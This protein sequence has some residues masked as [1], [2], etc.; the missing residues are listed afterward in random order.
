[1]DKELKLKRLSRILLFAATV[2]WGSTFFIMKNT[3]DT[4]G[5]SFIMAARFTIGTVLLTLIFLPRLKKFNVG[6]FIGGAITG[7][8]LALAS[9]VQTV[10][11]SYTTPGKNA[12]LT[13]VY[14]VIV[15]FLYWLTA[16]K[17]PTVYNVI[18][19]FICIV[20]IGFVTLNKDLKF[21]AGDMLTLLSGIFYAV[22][23]LCIKKFGENRDVFLF[24]IAQF[25]FTA[26]ICWI[27]FAIFEEFP[28][29]VDVGGWLTLLYLGVFGTTAAF[30]FMT[31]GVKYLPPSNSSLILS[32]ESVFGVLFSLIFYNEKITLTIALGFVM[33]FF[34][35]VL[36]ETELKFIKLKIN[37]KRQ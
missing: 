4:M 11:L 1:M 23:I 17:R 9:I 34:A 2:I 36:S 15:P 25:L 13:A 28:K 27:S 20:G 37:K 30:T 10:G 33:I 14:C 18:S 24:T 6:Y 19:A 31:F 32:L 5:S 22:Q 35:V 3:L 12:F 29:G 8:V 7:V 16:K 21:N 26:I